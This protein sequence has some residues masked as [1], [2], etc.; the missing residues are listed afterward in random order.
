MET[1]EIAE[2]VTAAKEY[3]WPHF[4][5][6]AS[7]FDL[8]ASIIDLAEGPYMVDIQG[9]RLLDTLSA[10]GPNILRHQA[11]DIYFSELKKNIWNI[12]K[13]FNG[14]IDAKIRRGRQYD[15]FSILFSI[16]H[17][18]LGHAIWHAA[19]NS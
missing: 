12:L 10:G 18:D 14:V 3:Y 9:R 7:W 4:A 17:F 6:D 5:H 8:P 2:L 1:N 13:N 19:M 15:F 11:F 16:A